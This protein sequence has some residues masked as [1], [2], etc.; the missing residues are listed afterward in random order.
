M[1]EP[2]ESEGTPTVTVR[3]D[4]DLVRMAR[5]VC[6]GRTEKLIDYLDAIARERITADYQAFMSGS[7]PPAKPA[8][9][10]AK[11]DK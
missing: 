3:M 2:R 9:R 7:A 11:G 1:S 8:K 6:A 10:R 4:S 5:V